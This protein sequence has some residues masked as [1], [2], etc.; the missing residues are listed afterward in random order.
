MISVPTAIRWPII[1]RDAAEF[2][3]AASA[4]SAYSRF[5]C[6]RNAID[7]VAQLLIR[8][9]QWRNETHDIVPGDD[10]QQF[11]SEARIHDVSEWH[12]QLR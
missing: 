8:H 9:I 3:T 11:L 5:E 4:G 1:M 2:A 10:G 12:L 6:S 7:R